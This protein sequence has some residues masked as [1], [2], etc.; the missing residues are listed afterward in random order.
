M[1]DLYFFDSGRMLMGLSI[2]PTPVREDWRPTLQR[3][4]ASGG[5]SRVA[6]VGPSLPRAAP[7]GLVASTAAAAEMVLVA[8]PVVTAEAMSEVT[9]AAPPPLVVVEEERETRLPASPSGGP[10]GS[11]S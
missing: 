4:M 5:E 1:T 10:R 11:P 8:I 9:L 2:A 6:A 7:L 3:I